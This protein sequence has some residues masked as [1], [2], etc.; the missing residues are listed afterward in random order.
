MPHSSLIQHLARTDSKDVSCVLAI[1]I[2]ISTEALMVV[3][4]HM[5]SNVF[6]GRDNTSLNFVSTCRTTSAP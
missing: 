6:T 1:N 5:G 2:A 4:D 3:L